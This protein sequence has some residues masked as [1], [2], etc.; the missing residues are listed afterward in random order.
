MNGKPNYETEPSNPA[1]EK[2]AEDAAKQAWEQEEQDKH[3][4]N[5]EK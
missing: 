4:A 5:N 3:D 2:A 1:E